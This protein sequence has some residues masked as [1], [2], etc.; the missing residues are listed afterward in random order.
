M[1]WLKVASAPAPDRQELPQNLKDLLDIAR[2][3]S[4]R[5]SVKDFYLVYEVVHSAGFGKDRFGQKLVEGVRAKIMGWEYPFEFN[6]FHKRLLKDFYAV[7]VSVPFTERPKNVTFG[8]I[9]IYEVEKFPVDDKFREEWR[10][11]YRKQRQTNTHLEEIEDAGGDPVLVYRGT[12][13]LDNGRKINMIVPM[14]WR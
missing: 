10:K 5:L 11:N 4:R 6:D 14:E 2:K 8:E 7:R 13:E 3:F 9:T 12:I 1:T